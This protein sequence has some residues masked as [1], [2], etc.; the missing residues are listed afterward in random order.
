M[1]L[2]WTHFFE[3]VQQKPYFQDLQK[4]LSEEEQQFTIYPAKKDRFR[5]FELTPIETMKVV[6]LGQDPYHQPN[7]ADGLAFSVPD[8][9]RLPPSL[10]NIYKEIESD[11]GVEMNWHSGN[12]EHW[13]K[14]GVFLLN[15][16]LSVKEGQPLSHKDLGYHKFLKDVLDY[17]NLKEE[18]LVF[19]LW[20][21]HAQNF[22]KQLAPHHVCLRANH[23]SPLS[24]N[25]GGW[26]GCKH[27]SQVNTLLVKQHRSPINWVNDI[28][29]KF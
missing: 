9:V 14:Q 19:L 11:L 24:A 8:G 13:A 29:Q 7:Q 25:R 18:P 3:T 2:S 28:L 22:Q 21:H 10:K 26:F 16:Y 23:P 6:I 4:K 27:F 1:K 12:L 5:A 20:G 15:T 17:L